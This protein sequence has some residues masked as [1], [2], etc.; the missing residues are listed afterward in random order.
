MVWFKESDSKKQKGV[1]KLGNLA[2]LLSILRKVNIRC[3]LRV[4]TQLNILIYDVNE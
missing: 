1:K 4:V 2:S 3:L